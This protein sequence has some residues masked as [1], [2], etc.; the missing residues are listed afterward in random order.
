[1]PVPSNPPKL[2][3]TFTIHSFLSYFLKAP[4][5]LRVSEA[6]PSSSIT[7][8]T[9]THIPL[10]IPS[11]S[12]LASYLLDSIMDSHS[13][14]NTPTFN[15]LDLP[16]ELQHMVASS[17]LPEEARLLR[18]TCRSIGSIADCYAFPSLKFYLHYEDLSMLRHF[19]DH[20]II[21]K[22]VKSLFYV[23]AT[24]FEEALEFEDFVSEK[25]ATERNSKDRDVDE[26]DT[27]SHASSPD[28][29]E[30]KAED[31]KDDY[32]HYLTVHQHQVRILNTWE[33]FT[34]LQHVISKFD[35]LS[36]I[37]VCGRR[38]LDD[39]PPLF[40]KTAFHALPILPRDE[41]GRPSLRQTVS[42]LTPLYGLGRNLTSLRL[43]ALDW[44]FLLQLEDESRLRQLEDLCA[45]LTTFELIL[46]TTTSSG[47]D[48]ALCGQAVVKGHLAQLLR[49][50]EHLES[51]SITFTYPRLKGYAYPAGVRDIIAADAHW[52]KLRHLKLS[53]VEGDR[54]E[55]LDVLRSHGST[56]K[57]VR[58]DRLCLIACSLHVFIDDLRC[59]ARGMS[60]D[61]ILITGRCIGVSEGAGEVPDG[62]LEDYKLSKF[63][64]EPG[65][66]QGL[67]EDISKYVLCKHSE[68]CA[69]PLDGYDSEEHS[70]YEDGSDSED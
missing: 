15:L 13:K 60:L 26:E 53:L 47:L 37:T 5:R 8:L 68:G 16:V 11:L 6:L 31:H 20:P 57:T 24:L 35:F 65:R 32:E 33:D 49:S 4:E 48:V 7:R 46:D 58:L 45:G 59:L 3:S 21:S 17:L 50:M 51:L 29:Y 42:L 28:Q 22:H 69:H 19:A 63:R 14:M 30:L 36:E 44:S 1:M 61:D 18:L 56:L 2:N 40:S 10:P 52:S 34:V 27:I 23:T 62:E 54:E 41:I 38:W 43:G 64:T 55:F 67:S 39:A 66:R 25:E 12:P 9:L 70:D